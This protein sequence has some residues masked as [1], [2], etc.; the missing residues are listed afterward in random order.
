MKRFL[1]AFLV[2]LML[3]SVAACDTPPSADT[4]AATEA[5]TQGRATEQIT[6]KETENMTEAVTEEQIV[7]E[8]PVFFEKADRFGCGLGENHR[9]RKRIRRRCAGQIHGCGQI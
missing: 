6:E 8:D 7:D 9:K 4:N 3:F 2:M 1:S 5:D